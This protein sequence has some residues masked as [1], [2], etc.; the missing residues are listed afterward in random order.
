LNLRP[1]ASAD[2][3]PVTPVSAVWP[4]RPNYG[5]DRLTVTAKRGRLAMAASLSAA[6]L[7]GCGVKSV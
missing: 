1:N 2:L 6:A 4:G 7:G 5:Q 3:R